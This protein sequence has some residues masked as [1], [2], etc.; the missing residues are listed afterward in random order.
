ME[1]L[2]VGLAS[3]IWTKDY[4]TAWRIGSALETGTVWVNTYRAVSPLVPFGGY[5]STP[6]ADEIPVPDAVRNGD[7]LPGGALAGIANF[8]F[9]GCD[10]ESLLL[11]LDALGNECSTGSAS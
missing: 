1:E 5:R 7:P 3:G 4:R 9:P 11:L 6:S 8:S 2:A 10:G